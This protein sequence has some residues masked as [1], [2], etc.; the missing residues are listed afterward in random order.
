ML[1]QGERE[2]GAV[3]AGGGRQA[4][5]LHRGARHRRQLD[6]AAAEDWYVCMFSWSVDDLAWCFWLRMHFIIPLSLWFL[7]IRVLLP[8]STYGLSSPVMHGAT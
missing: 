8:T 4:Q 7:L 3:V 2:E 6:R 5:G 1:R